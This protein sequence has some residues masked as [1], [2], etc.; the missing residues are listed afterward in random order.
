MTITP[1]LLVF[2]SLFPSAVRPSAGVFIR[3]RMFRVGQTLPLLV[4]SPVPWF[5]LQGLIRYWRPHFRPQP[6]HF[7]EQQGF[8]VYYPRF[9][10]LP[11]LLKRF[12]GFFMAVGC[13]PLLY[14]LKQEFDFNL[15][16]AHFAYPDGYAATVLA[17]WFK[18]PSTIT[19]RGTELPTSKMP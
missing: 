5:P 13:V 14:K 19:L 11:A 8:Q 18:V 1:R 4:V 17:A 6:A 15:I 10:S 2:S 9:C 7:E 3:E 16:D 12:D